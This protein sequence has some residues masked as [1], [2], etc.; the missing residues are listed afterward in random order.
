MFNGAAARSAPH[1]R[2]GAAVSDRS[3]WFDRYNTALQRLSP[4]IFRGVLATPPMAADPSGPV[5][6]YTLLHKAAARAYLL[7]AKSFLRFCPG[8]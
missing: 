2:A 7:A 5:V 4:W 8:L 3:P 1:P 6:L